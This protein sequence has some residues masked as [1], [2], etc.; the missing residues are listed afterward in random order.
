MICCMMKRLRLEELN[1]EQKLKKASHCFCESNMRQHDY[2]VYIMANDR[3]TL[4]IGVTNNLKSRVSSYKLKINKKCF[5]VRYEC[6]KLVY[7]EHFSNIN[8][9]IKREK[10]LS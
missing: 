6:F 5:P 9:A 10:N 4:Y 1:Q 3:P 2:Y 7:Y 8:D